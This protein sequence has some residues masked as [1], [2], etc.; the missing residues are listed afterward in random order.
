[1]SFSQHN[2][3]LLPHLKSNLVWVN[4][5]SELA[6]LPRPALFLDRDGVVIEE[7]H[8]LSSA[9]GVTLI[10][11]APEAINRAAARGYA[12]VIVS[13]QSGIGRGF[14]SW[15]DHKAVEERL[16][17]LLAERDANVDLSLACAHHPDGIAPYNVEHPWR[18]PGPGM[19]LEAR[20]LLNLDLKNSLM[21][22]DKTSDISA[23]R[24]AGLP[25]A[26]VTATGHGRDEASSATGLRRPGFTV[27][28]IASIDDVL[29]CD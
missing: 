29:R 24:A 8:Y 13:N 16:F 15:D 6:H 19:L 9:N 27:S 25:R 21:V 20:N 5:R 1:M 3:L 4:L 12:I 14:L 11:G 2:S 18:K 7:R 28:L 22:G 10:S 17:T 26:F 23:A